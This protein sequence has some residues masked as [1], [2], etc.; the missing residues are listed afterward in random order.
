MKVGEN[1]SQEFDSENHQRKNE[2]KN[3]RKKKRKYES[4][5]ERLKEGNKKEMME[6]KKNK[7][8]YTATDVVCGWAGAIFEVTKP[9]RKEQ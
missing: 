5:K 1:W 2:R 4:K 8:G 9:V 7:A 6:G 3:E